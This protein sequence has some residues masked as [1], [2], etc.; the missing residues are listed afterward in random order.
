MFGELDGVRHV[1][2]HEVLD[3]PDAVYVGGLGPWWELL[4]KGADVGPVSGAGEFG[5]FGAGGAEFGDG[6]GV[7]EVW[8]DDVA[9]FVELVKKGV[10]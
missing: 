10:G 4:G 5:D 2:V 6:F 3:A 9:G 8:D 1:G 7:D